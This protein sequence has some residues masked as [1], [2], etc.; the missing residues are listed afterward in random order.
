MKITCSRRLLFTLALGL[1]LA[2]CTLSTSTTP[3]FAFVVN[4]QAGAVGSVSSFGVVSQS[5]V[6]SP[7]GPAINTGPGPTS[8]AADS[9][10]HFLYV[11]NSDGTVSGFGIHRSNG[12]L[13][14]VTGSPFTVGVSPTGAVLDSK[15]K[16][17][18]VANNGSNNISAFTVNRN[19]GV[20][21]QVPGSPFATSS[22]PL[23]LA[24]HPKGTLLYVTLGPGGTEVFSIGATG[25]LTAGSIVP[26]TSG[27]DASDIAIAPSG[28]FAYVADGSTGVSAYKIDSTSGGLTLIAGSP[29]FA[30]S[31]PISVAVDP[32]GRY[33]YGSLTVI[34][35]SPFV[36]GSSPI[37]VNVDPSGRF[38]YVAN[39]DGDNVSYFS[40]DSKIAGAL[41]LGGTTNTG[42]NPAA[43]VTVR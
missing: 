9:H 39:I 17:L 8:I 35:G 11:T 28:Q 6:L 2:G 40:I 38:V 4:N 30:G 26:P 1:A 25:A 15:T 22:A 12:S 42:R 31:T 27:A 16:F 37:R 33:V 36:A 19:N 29:F 43:V 18:F 34:E 10:G 23:H 5:G 21:T 7:A 14:S 20:L 24:V 3:K 13:F 32:K 41:L